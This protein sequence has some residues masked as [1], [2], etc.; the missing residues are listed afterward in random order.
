MITRTGTSD[1][2]L[3]APFRQRLVTD[4]IYVHYCMSTFEDWH[5]LGFHAMQYVKSTLMMEVTV[6]FEASVQFA[7]MH[8]VAYQTTTNF[9]VIALRSSN[10]TYPLVNM[11]SMTVR[12]VSET[13]SP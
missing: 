6:S 12:S 10:V 13:R 7:R 8:N 3:I 9:I 5:F 2:G 11:F 4:E 1:S